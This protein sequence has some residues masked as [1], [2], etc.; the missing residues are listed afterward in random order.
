MIAADT[1]LMEASVRQR[2][3]AIKEKEIG[4]YTNSFNTIATQAAVLAGFSF[5]ALCKD[6]WGVNGSEFE[7]SPFHRFVFVNACTAS[8]SC[9]L[10]AV[11]I[12]TFCGILGPRLA[13]LGP[14]GATN[15]ACN[16]LR[17]EHDWACSSHIAGLAFFLVSMM[18]I[19][20]FAFSL[21]DA[22]A[23]FFQVSLAIIGICLALRRITTEFYFDELH[24]AS[25]FT[26]S[27]QRK[28]LYRL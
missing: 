3:L 23:M 2:Q 13:L 12:S 11:V 17:R 21:F 6:E 16:S 5:G 22:S 9:N 20:F 14:P 8:V 26:D 10:A 1:H 15:S 28:C 18:D 19:G 4:H 27:E 24:T 7:V 25:L